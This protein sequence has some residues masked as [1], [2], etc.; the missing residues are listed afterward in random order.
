MNLWHRSFTAAFRAFVLFVCVFTNLQPALADD[1]HGFVFKS[2]VGFGGGAETNPALVSYQQQDLLAP[3][4]EGTTGAYV[5]WRAGL[6]TGYNGN[7]LAFGLGGSY[8][9][10]YWSNGGQDLLDD[11][12]LTAKV[13]ILPNR[14]IGLDLNGRIG[15]DRYGVGYDTEAVNESQLITDSWKIE[16]LP[17]YRIGW[18]LPVSGLFRYQE[19]VYDHPTTW[20]NTLSLMTIGTST[21]WQFFPK[22]AL[23][24][25][26]GYRRGASEK[27]VVMT[28]DGG[29]IKGGFDGNLFT[30]IQLFMATGY[31]PVVYSD[32][33]VI[34]DANAFTFQGGLR[35]VRP[36]LTFSAGFFRENRDIYWTSAV[37]SQA[38]KVEIAYKNDKY[39]AAGF[40][41]SYGSYDYLLSEYSTEWIT[42]GSLYV[43]DGYK[44]FAVRLTVN[45]DRWDDT[46]DN[47]AGTLVFSVR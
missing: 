4:V 44:H 36:G 2:T 39:D 14:R 15:R 5:L 46:R 3:V 31:N 47:L 45:Y 11:G 30:R 9:G 20:D 23:W 24:A 35:Y 25:E 7:D 34:T 18:A 6:N 10:K 19:Q 43:E 13:R 38:G 42:R 29:Y 22:S 1:Q 28:S 21:R 12:N 16:A 8:Q 27:E 33:S 32:G 17:T 40:S 41:A 37:L 26:G